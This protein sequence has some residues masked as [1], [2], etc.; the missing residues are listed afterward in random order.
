[1][2]N[3]HIDNI[4]ETVVF[5]N[6]FVIA[7]A[8]LLFGMIWIYF[9]DRVAE[10]IS[11]NSH[12]LG[13]L[14][15]YKGWF[16]I[17]ITTLLLFILTYR[18]LHRQFTE[19][20]QNLYE[21]NRLQASLRAKDQLLSQTNHIAKIGGWSFDT[22]TLQGKW[23]DE[24][25][26]MHEVPPD[27]SIDLEK[28]LGFYAPKSRPIIEKA[29]D[30]IMERGVPFDLQLEI[31]TRSGIHK[32]IRNIGAPLMR[33][34][35]VIKVQGVI[36]DITEQRNAQ[37]E[38]DRYN[39]F[40]NTIVN[41][42]PDA[43]FVKDLEGKYLLFNEGAANAVGI[44]A[45][46][47]IGRTD[48][49]VFSSQAAMEIKK[50]DNQIIESGSVQSHEEDLIT[51]N[52]EE[53]MFLVTKG[54]IKNSDGE[55]FGLF[56]I[57]RDITQ[58][59]AD[60]KQ[61]KSEKERYDYTA[62]HDI[63]TGL[64]NNLSLME[65]TK[66]MSLEPAPFAFMFIDLDAFKEINDSYG[67]AFGDQLL[68]QIKSMLQSVFPKDAFIVRTG[69]D[70]F[71][72]ILKCREDKN[73]IK[74]SIENLIMHLNHPL[75]VLNIDI[76][77]TASIGIALY[78]DDA[79][80]YEELLQKSD[81]AMYHAKKIGKNTFSFYD[82]DMTKNT[83]YRT[84]IMTNLKKA[85]TS[86]EL[87][88]YFQPQVDSK[89][90]KIIG[91]E[92]LIR[93]FTPE[94]TISPAVFIPIAEESSL[95]FDI[96]RFVLNECFK[97]AVK[98]SAL[99]LLNGRISV[100][101]SARQLIHPDFLMILEN[102]LEETKCDPKWIEIEITESSILENPE[103]IIL[104][105][106]KLRDKGFHISLDDFGTGYSSMSYLKNLPINKL[107][108][109]QSFIQ[110]IMGEQK[111]QTIVQTI[112]ALAKGLRIEVIAE[113][114]ETYDELEFLNLC[115]I[116]SIQGYYY[117]KPMSLEDVEAVLQKN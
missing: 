111:N 7:A 92:A 107:K 12:A 52:G 17:F 105:L 9:S 18:F 41:S 61:L 113:G 50:L 44:P 16:F 78:P 85:L 95:I 57:S 108:I 6:A 15:T 37:Q 93:W 103:K 74:E 87:T 29:I 46:K 76:Y 79:R 82:A 68:I 36:Q 117:Y 83:L 55:L 114:V 1:M 10:M 60:Q 88:V 91:A 112:I 32:W 48:E 25:A 81:T 102:L 45:D 28:A 67:H 72:I 116:D 63:L 3:Q 14:Q 70:E 58:Q 31:I 73:G 56:G 106:E 71:V 19:Y 40:L 2:D 90:E 22:S 33:A 24:L 35:K 62:H 98:W 104:L 99:G 49:F 4:K 51:A 20:K 64:P 43:I 26:F 80:S 21:Q 11:M 30:D 8:Y 75:S 65:Y 5:K 34:E 47:V 101:V 23:T 96:G 13:L 115:G 97:L 39:T 38:I 42:S 59:K 54:P 110:S 77:I 109:D 53:K 94:E 86:D 84:T 100:N 89:T 69:G 27:E 66:A